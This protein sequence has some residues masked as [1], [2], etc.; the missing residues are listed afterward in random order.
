M[1]VINSRRYIEQFEHFHNSIPSFGKLKEMIFLNFFKWKFNYKV[2][3]LA[4]L[5]SKNLTV[6]EV[7]STKF[8]NR[9]ADYILLTD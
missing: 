3:K 9:K 8:K 5:M 7:K 4:I 6:S 2:L 1:L